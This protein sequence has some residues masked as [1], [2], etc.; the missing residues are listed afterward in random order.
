MF[1]SM[2]K[3]RFISEALIFSVLL[4]TVFA[5][6]TLGGKNSLALVREDN[7]VL[8]LTCY[9]LTFDGDGTAGDCQIHS[10]RV[11]TSGE[12]VVINLDGNNVTVSVNLDASRQNN[13]IVV[14]QAT[15][16]IPGYSIPGQV[17]SIDISPPNINFQSAE[18]N[19]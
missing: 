8:S 7:P 1:E 15:I 4:A 13:G 12:T 2:T 19:S 9:S 16:Y 17:T 5:A 6:A 18:L 3:R 10:S 11:L 14:Y